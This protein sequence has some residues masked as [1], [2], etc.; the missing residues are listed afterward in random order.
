MVRALVLA[1]AL[2]SLLGCAVATP[3][4]KIDTSVKP[5]FRCGDAGATC[6]AGYANWDQRF[7]LSPGQVVQAD[8]PGTQS[9]D[10]RVLTQVASSSQS[11]SFRAVTVGETLLTMNQ[12]G[13]VFRLR[14]VVIPEGLSYD[15]LL[16][17]DNS[18][19]HVNLPIGKVVLL[20]L[21][22]ANRDFGPWRRVIIDPASLL[23]STSGPT[24]T[25]NGVMVA[26]YQGA[27]RGAATITGYSDP[28]PKGVAVINFYA[29]VSA[30]I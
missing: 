28:A 12:K 17:L 5:D 9:D 26:T 23:V 22:Q 1:L 13:H 11:V 29:D 21:V 18:T 10:S 27:A 4:I 25:S 14:V 15:F 30:Q 20:V 19:E 16:T 24:V 7:V 6:R 2:V 3:A 8:V